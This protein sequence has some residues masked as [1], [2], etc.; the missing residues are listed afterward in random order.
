MDDIILLLSLR[1]P[2]VGREKG[3]REIVEKN[4]GIIQFSI[5][6]KNKTVERGKS[7]RGSQPFLPYVKMPTK[8]EGNKE[9]QGRLL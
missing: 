9:G 6:C 1:L 7:Q 8:G 4:C 3:V 2:G 5:K